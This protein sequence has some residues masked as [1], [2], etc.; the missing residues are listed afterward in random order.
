[1]DRQGHFNDEHLGGSRCITVIVLARLDTPTPSIELQCVLDAK[2]GRDHHEVS[3]G[4]P[5]RHHLHPL[6]VDVSLLE[7]ALH[8]TFSHVPKP[9]IDA[10]PV[11]HSIFANPD[12]PFDALFTEEREPCTTDELTISHQALPASRWKGLQQALHQL[13][14]NVGLAVAIV[15][16]R[17]PDQR[18]RVAVQDDAQHQEVQ[19]G[20][21]PF[22][23]RTVKA[24]QQFSR[25]KE[26]Q[27]QR[28]ED[29]IGQLF[30][31]EGPFYTAF[32]GVMRTLAWQVSAQCAQVDGLTGD[33]GLHHID[34]ALQGVDAQ[35]GV[36]GFETSKDFARLKSGRI[37][38]RH[39]PRTL[40]VSLPDRSHANPST[41][42][43]W[44]RLNKDVRY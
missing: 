38:S 22:P 8:L 39:T 12:G 3:R 41:F 42:P 35:M 33:H 32:F 30:I 40:P 10:E 5:R 31:P 14:T 24:Q 25:W 43:L 16:K 4:R 36:Q 11:H 44:G 34:H 27:D 17:R 18:Q 1:V 23:G 28:Q 29:F 26:R 2:I 7:Q 21:P 6:A 13:E 9:L 20:V 19:R 15:W 37:W